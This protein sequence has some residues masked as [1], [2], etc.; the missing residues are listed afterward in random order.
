MTWTYYYYTQI[1]FAVR[2]EETVHTCSLVKQNM[3]SI[4]NDDRVTG[5]IGLH[6]KNKKKKKKN[7][8]RKDKVSD[9]KG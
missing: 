3:Y 5:L 1:T 4:W 6:V 8:L 7:R 9:W 2:Y